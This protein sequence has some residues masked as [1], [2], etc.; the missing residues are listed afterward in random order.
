M[1]GISLHANLNLNVQNTQNNRI[2]KFKLNGV[3]M[4]R[5]GLGVVAE[6]G[7]GEGEA[8]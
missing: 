2:S 5:V 3:F 1:V 6:V 4:V 8:K 7:V